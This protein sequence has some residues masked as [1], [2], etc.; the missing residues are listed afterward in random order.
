V[1]PRTHAIWWGPHTQ[2]VEQHV[3]PR[4]PWRKEVVTITYPVW[5]VGIYDPM[6]ERNAASSRRLRQL[7]TLQL[8]AQRPQNLQPE[9]LADWVERW[10]QRWRAAQLEYQGFVGKFFWPAADLDWSVVVEYEC[11]GWFAR[12]LFEITRRAVLR[13]LE[14]KDEDSENLSARDQLIRQAIAQTMPSIWRHVFR[15][16]RSIPVPSAA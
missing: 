10:R 1:D 11:M 13:D 3:D 15:G 5:L 4:R 6:R 14:K 7:D 12:H 8:P 2:H 16:R 9:E